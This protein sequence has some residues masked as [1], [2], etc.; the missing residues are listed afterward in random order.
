MY[1]DITGDLIAGILLGQLV[2]WYLP[3][4]QGQSKLRVKKDG[5]EWIAKK[6][7]D[8]YEEVRIS[9]RQYDRASKKLAKLDLIETNLY[10]FNGVPTTHIRLN[11]K[12]LVKMVKDYL[13]EQKD[14]IDNEWLGLWLEEEDKPEEKED[15]QETWLELRK[16][17]LTKIG[18]LDLSPSDDEQLKGDIKRHGPEVVRKA[19]KLA[20]K[21]KDKQKDY[22][23][24][25]EKL[26]YNINTYKYIQAFIPDVLGKKKDKQAK[27]D[28]EFQ[29]YELSS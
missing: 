8:W 26:G 7:N 13:Q 18:R 24:G 14:K 16:E 4:K 17:I 6:R 21:R 25:Q 5:K 2:W 12:K 19:L 28:N 1:V 10:K 11:K 27:V 29:E 22:R 23:R 9:A 15:N 20:C 3:N